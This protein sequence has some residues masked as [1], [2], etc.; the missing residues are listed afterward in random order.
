MT[1]RNYEYDY[2]SRSAKR[3]ITRGYIQ[4]WFR[5]AVSGLEEEDVYPNQIGS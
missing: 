3:S 2:S 5:F 4:E 1:R